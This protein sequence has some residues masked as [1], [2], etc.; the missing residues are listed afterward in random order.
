MVKIPHGGRCM[1][2]SKILE[3]CSSLDFESMQ[4]MSKPDSEGYILV[5]CIEWEEVT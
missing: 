4:P 1:V 2:C 3:N 5:K